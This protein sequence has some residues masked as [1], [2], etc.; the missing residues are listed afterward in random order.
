MRIVIDTNVL[1][2]AFISSRGPAGE[3]LA[4]ILGSNHQLVTSNELL[5]ELANVLRH[6]RVARE[7]G[8]S[9]ETIYAFVQNL[10]QFAHVVTLNP[11]TF[12]PIRDSGDIF[13]LQTVLEGRA[14]VICTE[15]RDFFAPPAS[16]YLAECG[17]AVMTHIALLHRLR[18]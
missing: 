18:Q 17:I 16:T 14:G 12:A 2:R 4:T 11:L 1:V 15:D 9:E 3:L 10:R 6:P 13:V 8:E 5:R 7:H